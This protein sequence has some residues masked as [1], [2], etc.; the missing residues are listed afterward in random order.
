MNKTLRIFCMSLLLG[1]LFYTSASG[2]AVG[3]FGTMCN[4]VGPTWTWGNNVAGSETWGIW[5]GTQFNATTSNPTSGDNA[6]I[7]T[8]HTVKLN[9]SGPWAV[10]NLTIESGGKLWTNSGG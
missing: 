9:P 6:Y 3:D 5:D 4:G 7:R 8:G 2:Y 1:V 10:K